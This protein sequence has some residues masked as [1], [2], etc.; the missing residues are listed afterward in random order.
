[1]EIFWTGFTD[2]QSGLDHFEACIGTVPGK[3]DV[4]SNFNCLLASSHIKTGLDLP[5]NTDLYVTITA[6]NKVN[7]NMSEASNHFRVDS[8]PPI[9]QTKPKFFR[10]YTSFENVSAQWEKSLLRIYWKFIDHESPIVR[11]VVTLVTH[12]EGHTPVEHVEIGLENKLTISLDD[13][14]W[15]HNG[16]TYKV[17]VTACNAAGLCTTAE[18]ETLLIDSTPAHLGGFKPPMS[19]LNFIDTSGTA[20]AEMN[21]TWYGFH[22]QESGI[23]HFYIGV[24]KSYS[25]NELSN[26][27]VRI[28]P[29]TRLNIH[30]TSLILNEPLL[31]NAKIVVAIMAENNAGLMSSISRVTLTTLQTIPGKLLQA[32]GGLLEIEKHSC[33][34]H[35]CNKDCTCAVVGQP[36]AFLNTNSTCHS[37]NSTADNPFNLTVNVYGGMRGEIVKITASSSCLAAHWIVASGNASIKRFEWSL[38]IKDYNPGEGIFDS[39]ELPWQ[40]I[41]TRTEIVNCLSQNR[42]LIHETEYIAYVRVWVEADKYLVFKSLP[43]MVDHTAPAIRKGAYVKDSDSSCAFEYDVIDWADYISACWHGVFHEPQGRIVYYKIALGTSPGGNLGLVNT[44]FQSDLEIINSCFQNITMLLYL[45]KI[46]F[47]NNICY[48]VKNWRRYNKTP[49]NSTSGNL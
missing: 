15:L 26:G 49:E 33:D 6:Y 45:Y 37:V 35:F 7:M 22:D 16:D 28:V 19:W 31:S 39:D 4:T 13:K 18:S 41:G 46:I 17:L 1:M 44:R 27:L 48:E 2:P 29:N 3:C 34:I 5:K 43:I 14:H 40:D 12:H 42:S 30:N 32:A 11:H 47:V 36:C 25:G 8:S 21:L 10:N 9:I 20:L 23:K 38:G 24:G